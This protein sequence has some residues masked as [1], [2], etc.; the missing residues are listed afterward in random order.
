MITKAETPTSFTHIYSVLHAGTEEESSLRFGITPHGEVTI[1]EMVDNRNILPQ[2]TG[3]S[4][5]R[6]DHIIDTIRTSREFP[7]TPIREGVMSQRE[8]V[9]LDGARAISA[10]Y[11]P[12]DPQAQLALETE[13]R[14]V[15]KDHPSKVALIRETIGGTD[16]AIMREEGLIPPCGRDIIE[17]LDVVR[18]EFDNRGFK[19]IQPLLYDDN[20]IYY[21]LP[22]EK[23]QNLPTVFS[24]LASVN[25]EKTHEIY[26]KLQKDLVALAESMDSKLCSFLNSL[27]MKQIAKGYNLGDSNPLYNGNGFQRSDG[28]TIG[29]RNSF[30]GF[31]E[32]YNSVV[33]DR[34]PNLSYNWIVNATETNLIRIQEFL[35]A[36][37]IDAA[38]KLLKESMLC[39]SPVTLLEDT[40]ID[41]IR[42]VE[43]NNNKW[44]TDFGLSSRKLAFVFRKA[45]A[46]LITQRVL[47]SPWEEISKVQAPSF[48]DGIG[49]RVLINL[50]T[51]S[52]DLIKKFAGYNPFCSDN[53][54]AIKEFGLSFGRE[55]NIEQKRD[56]GGYY[57]NE[58]KIL[59]G[60][61]TSRSGM[62]GLS[63]LSLGV[64]Q[65][66]SEDLQAR[67]VEDLWQ[68]ESKTA[69]HEVIHAIVHK[70]GSP[71]AWSLANIPK[72]IKLAEG[73]WPWS[74]TAASSVFPA[75]LALDKVV[76]AKDMLTI[77][78]VG[79]KL[80]AAYVAVACSSF[81][82]MSTRSVYNFVKSKIGFSERTYTYFN[83]GTSSVLNEVVAHSQDRRFSGY[84]AESVNLEYY[85]F[86]K[87]YW[88][89]KCRTSPEKKDGVI[90]SAIN[91]F[92][93][94]VW[95][96][97]ALGIEPVDIA[98]KYEKIF[99]YGRV[100]YFE[101][102]VPKIKER[103][104]NLIIE[105]LRDPGKYGLTSEQVEELME[106]LK[107]RELFRL[108][109]R[110]MSDKP[111][112]HTVGDELLARA[113]TRACIEGALIQG[114][115]VEET[116]RAAR[117]EVSRLRR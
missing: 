113:N 58:G 5:Q 56:M 8:V 57:N 50:K 16:V 68:S 82:F 26:L 90:R 65:L 12:D 24:S 76:S 61:A 114:A 6:R 35:K 29:Y 28:K 44:T 85:Y 54:R 98:Q 112:I 79:L 101:D 7:S 48:W 81:F 104:D 116:N 51:K 78:D 94:R 91:A 49:E 105:Q 102:E 60:D 62:K 22:F 83:Q 27:G 59:L 4:I 46:Y 14:G 37:D 38:Y 1:N 72:W 52:L 42:E 39:L 92:V 89:L 66:S 93:A 55:K 40:D 70:I 21:T 31:S 110:P 2:L 115:V 32:N 97:S 41:Y 107:N 63:R 23:F 11:Y 80:S 74:L 33:N 86:T 100:K 19:L 20:T 43:E 47:S 9:F 25:P 109:C 36:E 75:L 87:D 69:L 106:E 99:D 77:G 15:Q 96:L 95:I 34:D 88:E 71:Y 67:I 30:T 73:L 84:D 45:Q 103:L 64:Y 10:Y 18:S 108:D 53:G 13:L 117:R 17:V 3:S 111:S